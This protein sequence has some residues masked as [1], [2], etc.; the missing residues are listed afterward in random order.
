MYGG[1]RSRWEKEMI[2]EGT[3]A[4]FADTKL[5][6]PGLEEEV[7][8]VQARLDALAA[9]MEKLPEPTAKL[10]KEEIALAAKRR[11]LIHD[12]L[13]L[14]ESALARVKER[15]GLSDEE[16]AAYARVIAMKQAELRRLI[17]AQKKQA[18]EAKSGGKAPESE[19]SGAG[20]V[21]PTKSAPPQSTT[22]PSSNSS[23]R[24]TE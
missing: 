13:L 2:I 10:S 24:A 4:H 19:K 11:Q 7:G 12:N 9:E 5:I 23:A 17:E 22:P 3:V 14:C 21:G 18:G 6:R 1:W 20:A 15:Y 16:R 8:A